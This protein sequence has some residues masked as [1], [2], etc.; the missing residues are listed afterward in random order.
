M[1]EYSCRAS[2]IA[3]LNVYMRHLNMFWFIYI[4]ANRSLKI[5]IAPS[6]SKP[7]N[8]LS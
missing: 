8:A 1:L 6:L 4:L 2:L 7:V 3:L 5:E